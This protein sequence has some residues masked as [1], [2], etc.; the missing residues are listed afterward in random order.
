MNGITCFPPYSIEKNQR[1]KEAKEEA[2]LEIEAYRKERENQFNEKRKK[3]DGSK[4]DFKLQMDRDKQDKLQ[5]IEKDVRAHKEEVI[6]K[7]LGMV[8]DIKPEKHIN[9]RE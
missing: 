2:G 6:D 7:L 9:F 4:D 1:L 3:F 5:Q 8:Y